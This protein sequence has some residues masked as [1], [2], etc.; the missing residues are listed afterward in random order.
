MDNI[1]YPRTPLQI[2]PLAS[3]V[4][5]MATAR[6]MLC[7]GFQKTRPWSDVTGC[8]EGKPTPIFRGRLQSALTFCCLLICGLKVRF[9]RGSPLLLLFWPTFWPTFC[10]SSASL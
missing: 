3:L 2:L 5:R 9:F 10:E 8:R 6:A 4:S 7:N 1:T